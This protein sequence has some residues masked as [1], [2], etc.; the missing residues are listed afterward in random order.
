L[1]YCENRYSPRVPKDNPIFGEIVKL[2]FFVFGIELFAKREKFDMKKNKVKTFNKDLFIYIFYI[3]T[4]YCKIK[5][6]IS[7]MDLGFQFLKT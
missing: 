6:G 2:Q 1:S 5:E 4:F 7:H 3:N